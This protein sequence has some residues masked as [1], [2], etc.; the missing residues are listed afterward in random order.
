MRRDKMERPSPQTMANT[1]KAKNYLRD[2]KRD[3]AKRK[4][5]VLLNQITK[6]LKALCLRGRS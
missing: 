1:E 6:E 5:V 3:Y 4:D 2:L